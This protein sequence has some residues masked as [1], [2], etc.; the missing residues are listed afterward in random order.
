MTGANGT[1]PRGSAEAQSACLQNVIVNATVKQLERQTSYQPSHPLRLALQG[2]N[3][4]LRSPKHA[5]IVTL[6]SSPAWLRRMVGDSMAP[7]M[8]S[9]ITRIALSVRVQSLAGLAQSSDL[10]LTTPESLIEKLLD[11]GAGLG[12]AERKE[13]VQRCVAML[14]YDEDTSVHSKLTHALAST[15]DNHAAIPSDMRSASQLSSEEWQVNLGLQ[16]M[17]LA[18]KTMIRLFE[19]LL[20]AVCSDPRPQCPVTLDDI[21]IERTCILTCC[22]AVVD[23]IIVPQLTNQLCPACRKSLAEGVLRVSKAVEVIQQTV[24]PVQPEPEPEPNRIG[25]GDVDA[26]VEA[27]KS[28]AG[29][30][31]KSSIDAVT[32]A[33]NLALQWMPKVHLHTSPAIH[34]SP[35]AIPF[36]TYIT[37]HSPIA[38]SPVI[39]PHTRV[40][41]CFCAS[42]SPTTLTTTTCE[43][44]RSAVC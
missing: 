10:L 17:R 8:P 16:R 37:C 5:A 38:S 28:K 29:L 39:T 34:C 20:E 2:R 33:L 9:G 19:R 6:C 32:T 7:L 12:G 1:E 21:P 15:Q 40:C 44:T 35:A 36:I 27:Y 14:A 26:L 4:S 31:C 11:N 30:S 42:T 43:R 3:L 23:A 25:V 41:A 24:E 13:F 22:G 18:H